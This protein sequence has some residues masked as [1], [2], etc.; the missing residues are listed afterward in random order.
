MN[1]NTIFA[2]GLAGACMLG[3]LS[4]VARADS[5]TINHLADGP[6]TLTVSNAAR[7]SNV[8]AAPEHISFDYAIDANPSG[9]FTCKYFEAG[10]QSNPVLSDVMLVTFTS[11]N[12]HF[13]FDSDFEGVT[14][15]PPQFQ[16]MNFF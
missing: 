12:A 9:T 3:A 6:P 10:T 2:A 8:L 15:S 7:L 14:L 11:G 16:F 5:V 13:T 4:R 1:G